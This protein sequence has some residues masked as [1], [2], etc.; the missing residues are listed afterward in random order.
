MEGAI[1]TRD[2]NK[3]LED[4]KQMNEYWLMIDETE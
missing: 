2:L 1:E 3:F 4:A